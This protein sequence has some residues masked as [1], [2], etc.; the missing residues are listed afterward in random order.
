MLGYF[1]TYVLDFDYLSAIEATYLLLKWCSMMC[2]AKIIRSIHRNHVFASAHRLL[3]FPAAY[4]YTAADM[5]VTAACPAYQECNDFFVTAF[6]QRGRNEK[7]MDLNLPKAINA[8]CVI[9]SSMSGRPVIG[10]IRARQAEVRGDDPK[11][12]R[13][14]NH[15]ATAAVGS[16]AIL[17]FFPPLSTMVTL[18]QLKDM[19][20]WMF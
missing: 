3:D 19:K 18:D 16:T 9:G 6:L 10:K 11:L 2:R 12:H 7:V 1:E 8:H 5:P 4:D 15:I 13:F 20:H 14:S 17:Q